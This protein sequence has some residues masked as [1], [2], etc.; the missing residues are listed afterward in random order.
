[1]NECIAGFFIIVCWLI[2]NWNECLQFYHDYFLSK[3]CLS[4]P[5]CP[6]Y[7]PQGDLK[8]FLEKSDKYCE[9]MEIEKNQ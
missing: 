4:L 8:E 6:Y 2:Y 1:L 3:Y 9:G 5:P 7:W